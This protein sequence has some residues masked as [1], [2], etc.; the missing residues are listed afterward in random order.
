VSAPVCET[1]L[2]PH[3][4]AVLTPIVSSTIAASTAGPELTTIHPASPTLL[5]ISPQRDDPFVSPEPFRQAGA[6]SSPDAKSRLGRRAGRTHISQAG[7]GEVF[8][9]IA[10]STT[11]RGR[12]SVI[13]V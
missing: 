3:T 10:D 11:P 6:I 13:V 5:S 7:L 9:T 4:Q 12:A 8:G 1:N 2:S